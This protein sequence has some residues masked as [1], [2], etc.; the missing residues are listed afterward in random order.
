MIQALLCDI[1]GTLLL[2]NAAHARSWV[3]AFAHYGR[4]VG[5]SVVVK[6]IGMGGDKLIPAIFPDLNK[7]EGLGKEVA[8]YRTKLFLDEYAPRLEPAPGARE[9]IEDV[10]R[11][12]VRTI[13][14]SSAGSQE[15][16]ALLRA[17]QVDDLLTEHTTAS[18]AGASKPDPDIVGVALG[19]AGVPAKAALML[20]DA[21]Y[22]IEAAHAVAVDVIA[23]RCGGYTDEELSGALAIYDDPAD[24]LGHLDQSA[25]MR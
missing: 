5:Y 9:F 11:R 18:E 3:E 2:S 16:D 19:K 10:Q 15:L 17:A 25:I 21:P 13:V 20:G 14:A 4:E 23:V 8:E 22:D 24:L 6:L 7:D 12:G 1:D